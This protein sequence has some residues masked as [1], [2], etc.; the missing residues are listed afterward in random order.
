MNRT[1]FL[2]RVVDDDEAMR[3][4][5]RFL[6]E[7][8]GFR[9]RTFESA[10]AFIAGDS[11][12]TP[13]CLLLDVKMTGMSGLELQEYLAENQSP[14][15]VVFLS[16]HG[17]IDMAVDVL[18]RGAVSFLS[19]PVDTRRLLA[20]LDMA[21]AAVPPSPVFGKEEARPPELSDRERQIVRFVGRGLTN[22]AIAEALGISK[23][24][25]EFHRASAMRKL[26][27]RNASELLEKFAVLAG[28]QT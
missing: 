21:L 25:V 11:A 20:A 27:A 1:E 14:L 4:A 17:S 5:M 26:G 22:R 13:G 28:A 12:K 7:G 23:R 18:H 24:T 6:L 3:D 2:V 10:E 19:K 15:P 16:A 9:V 8:E